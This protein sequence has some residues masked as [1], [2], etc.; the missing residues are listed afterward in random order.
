MKSRLVIAA[1][2]AITLLL[3][4]SASAVTVKKER[5]IEIIETLA[6]KGRA[7]KTGYDR[8]S[9]SHWRDP[10]RNG[11][12]ARN[13]ILRR[14]LTNLLIKSD[15]NGCKVLGGVL[16]DPYSGKNIDFVFG[17]SLI[18]IDHVVAL[19]NAWQ[20][21]AFQ[22]TSEIRLQFANDPLNLLAV[23]ASLNRQKGDGDAATWLPPTKSYR[24]QY[25][26]RQIAVKKKYG[27]WITKPEK[28]AMSTLLAKCPKE[29]IPNS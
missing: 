10:D 22:F 20:T 23:S 13:D 28:V 17:A 29:E 15:S 12:D 6:V 26:A 21:G 9:F 19:S 2:L 5:A 1:L 8:S 14:D 11:C 18:D 7:A 4:E 16:A 27:L 3:P 24:C 25:V